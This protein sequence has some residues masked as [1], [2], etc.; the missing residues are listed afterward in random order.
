MDKVKILEDQLKAQ[1][2]KKENLER[3]IRFIELKL[4]RL[5]LTAKEG[6]PTNVVKKK[7]K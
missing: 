3:N 7:S 5:K 6:K 2:K 1:M 4:E